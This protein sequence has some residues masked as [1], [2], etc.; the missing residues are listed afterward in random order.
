MILSG[1]LAASPDWYEKNGDR[2]KLAIRKTHEYHLKDTDV[3]LSTVQLTFT[4]SP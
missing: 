2:P 4:I 1:P 3:E